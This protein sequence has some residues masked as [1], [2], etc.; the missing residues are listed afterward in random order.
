[1]DSV[2]EF[3]KTPLGM[4]VAAV[5]VL[6]LLY[7]LFGDNFIGTGFLDGGPNYRI[8]T[9]GASQ[10][11]A[12]DFSGTNQGY[13]GNMATSL[14]YPSL[15]ELRN[16]MRGAETMV[17]SYQ[18][19]NFIAPNPA[20]AQAQ[21]AWTSWKFDLDENALHQSLMNGQN[22]RLRDVVA[23]EGNYLQGHLF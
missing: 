9:S 11:F 18:D 6:L 3:F 21:K 22:V 5:V 16:E 12:T 4:V 13:P 14:H 2:M 23:Q 17:G 7:L 20:V 1:M 19:P 8:W 15:D 10:R